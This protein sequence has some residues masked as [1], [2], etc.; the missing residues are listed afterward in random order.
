M[1]VSVSTIAFRPQATTVRALSASD[2]QVRVAAWLTLAPTD[3]GWCL[4]LADGEPVF[5]G[6]GRDGRRECLEFAR[7]A[8]VL[9]LLT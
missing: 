7:A 1:I 4:R 9:T 8:G 2:E 6:I 3:A 5:E